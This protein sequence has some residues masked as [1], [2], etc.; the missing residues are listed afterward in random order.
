MVVFKILFVIPLVILL[1]KAIFLI[2]IEFPKLKN[3]RVIRNI[4]RMLFGK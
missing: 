2:L 3:K 1:V 4:G